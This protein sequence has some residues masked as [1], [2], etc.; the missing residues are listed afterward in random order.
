MK[1]QTCVFAAA[2]H[3][4]GRRA[5]QIGSPR[6]VLGRTKGALGAAKLLYPDPYGHCRNRTIRPA[7]CRWT[8]RPASGCLLSARVGCMMSVFEHSHDPNPTKTVGVS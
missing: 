7:G 8:V 6:A 4:T 2:T 3:C 5:A 1:C